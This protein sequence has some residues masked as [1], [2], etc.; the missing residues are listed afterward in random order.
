MQRDDEQVIAIT[1]RWIRDVVVGLNLCPFAAP[2]VESGNIFYQVSAATAEESLYRDLL[3]ALDRF[4]QMDEQEA[5]T[6]FLILSK[7]LDSFD[8]FNQFMA[9]VEEVL[10][11]SGLEGVI[12]L[13]GFH[14]DYLFADC[15][16]DDPANYTNRSPFPMFHLIRED[17][18]ESAVA[19]HPDPASIPVRNVALLRELGVE[20]MERRLKAC[21]E[22]S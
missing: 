5:A 12:Q 11:Q 3:E 16:D 1:E 17:D 4:Q 18:L 13:V 21:Y 22:L 8:V 14:P 20:E 6:G 10:E 7:G 15:E 19:S 9:L 2:V